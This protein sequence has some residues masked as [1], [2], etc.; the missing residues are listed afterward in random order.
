MTEDKTDAIGGRRRTGSEPDDHQRSVNERSLLILQLISKLLRHYPNAA[1]VTAL[2]TKL[3]GEDG[4]SWPWMSDLGLIQ[5]K[6]AHA[7]LTAS[8]MAVVDHANRNGTFKGVLEACEGEHTPSDQHAAAVLALLHAN[9]EQ[10]G[11]LKS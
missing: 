9:Y 1:D 4:S 3:Q 6:P 2:Y 11:K 10:S 5:G 7:W 8:G